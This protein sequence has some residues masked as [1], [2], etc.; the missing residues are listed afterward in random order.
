MSK[1]CFFSPSYRA[2][3]FTQRVC[4]TT[5]QFHKFTVQNWLSDTIFDLCLETLR[6][7]LQREPSE[8]ARKIDLIRRATERDYVDDHS[9]RT[10]EDV[11]GILR[12]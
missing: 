8:L 1:D 9:E 5:A 4:T 11:V 10:Q 3:V 7:G 2:D 6:D 12:N